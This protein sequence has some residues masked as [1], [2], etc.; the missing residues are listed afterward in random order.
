MGDNYIE[1]E[2][3]VFKILTHIRYRGVEIAV[4][5][6]TVDYLYKQAGDEY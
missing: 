3:E 4:I 5:L 2:D 1:I 6:E